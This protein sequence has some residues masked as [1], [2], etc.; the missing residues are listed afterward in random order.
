MNQFN[1]L[2]MLQAHGL[3]HVTF[4]KM[5]INEE[6]IDKFCELFGNGVDH[7]KFEKCSL[8][9]GVTF[10]DLF[11]GEYKVKYLEIK[12]SML[13]DDDAIETFRSIYP[14]LLRSVIFSGMKLNVK[15]IN[16]TLNYYSCVLPP[17]GVL[18]FKV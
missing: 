10:H 6:F 9:Q 1:S 8:A 17:D 4:R 11:Y 16:S 13:T 3:K 15:K 12:D 14:W 5:E 2:T 7:L 18:H